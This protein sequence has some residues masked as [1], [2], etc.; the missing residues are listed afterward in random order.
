MRSKS[1]LQKRSGERINSLGQNIKEHS[2][3][4]VQLRNFI[5]SL[6]TSSAMLNSFHVIAII[7]IEK[8]MIFHIRT[9][10]N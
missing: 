2:C 3:D 5:V 1:P 10:D 4:F 6:E 7:G 8:A 9:C